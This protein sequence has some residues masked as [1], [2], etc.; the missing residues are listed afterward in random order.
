[1]S[2]SA[3]QSL[4]TAPISCMKQQRP[5]Q[6]HRMIPATRIQQ[7]IANSWKVKEEKTTKRS[8]PSLVFIIDFNK[9]LMSGDILLHFVIYTCYVFPTLWLAE[10]IQCLQQLG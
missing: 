3:L 7:S 5:K 4:S 8:I 10:V 2:S 6:Q 9:T 1:M